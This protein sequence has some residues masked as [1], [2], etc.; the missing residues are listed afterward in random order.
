MC[1]DLNFRFET[2]GELVTGNYLRWNKI[3]YSG[4]LSL[5]HIATIRNRFFDCF[6]KQVY[7]HDTVDLTLNACVREETLNWC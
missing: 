4:F 5:S 1:H 6:V 3:F 2:V 7:V